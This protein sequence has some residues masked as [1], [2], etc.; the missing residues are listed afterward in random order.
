M[1]VVCK[2]GCAM[3]CTVL[4]VLG[5]I[6]LVSMGLAYGTGVRE[7]VNGPVDHTPDDPA[8]TAQACYVAAAIYV[9]YIAFCVCQLWVHKRNTAQRELQ[10]L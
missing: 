10:H 4:S 5:I 3:C 6:F 1:Y 8:L 7:L 9:G 2:P